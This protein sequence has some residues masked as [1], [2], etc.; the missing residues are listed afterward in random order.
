MIP[1]AFDYQAPKPLLK[2]SVFWPNI[3]TKPKSL[4][5]AIA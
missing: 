3:P 2:H 4:R 1:A 5:V